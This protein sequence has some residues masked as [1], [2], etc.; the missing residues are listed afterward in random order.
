MLTLLTT[1]AVTA[2]HSAGNDPAG[3]EAVGSVFGRLDTLAHPDKLVPALEQMSVVWALVFLVAGLVAM[4][5]GFKLYKWVTIILALAIGVFTGYFL[6][7]AI[8]AEYVVAGCLGLLLA[9]CCWPL[10]WP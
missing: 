5:N 6:G 10:D 9:V 4:V 1:L 2:S 3:F 7:K 8:N